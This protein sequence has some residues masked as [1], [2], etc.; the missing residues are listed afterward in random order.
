MK[1]NDC[2]RECGADREKQ[3]GVCGGGALPGIA[4]A[5]LH[6]WEEPCIS[7]VNGSGTV[8]FTG[9]ALRCVFCQNRNIARWQGGKGITVTPERLAD[10]F[11]NLQEQ[12]AHNINLVTPS[13][14]VT[15]IITALNLAKS[16]G[17]R[18]PVVYNTSSYEKVENLR[19]LEGLI[20]IWMPD[21]K[22]F[23]SELSARYSNAPDYFQ[24]ATAA[25]AE[26]VRQAGEPV[27]RYELMITQ[28]DEVKP[29]A[30]TPVTQ[31]D[32]VNHETTTHLEQNNNESAPKT[33]TDSAE[34]Q[35][36]K[37]G[38]LVRHLVLP[39]HTADSKKVL[40]YLYQTYGN[41]IYISIMN[42]YTPFLGEDDSKKYPEL[43]RRVTKR[44]YQRVV[45]YAIELGIENAFIQEGETA[46]ES[47]IP[48]W[49]I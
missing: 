47:F 15:A 18:I 1:C 4:R 38:V 32:K 3:R 27:L 22:Y 36:L 19:R 12:G 2:P 6:F 42:Q 20:D 34:L 37:R 46:E 26:M 45:D 17:L 13:H 23:S 35:L 21:L 33:G 5:A 7:G 8:F 29:V 24:V 9:C 31:S 11:L 41:R 30:A 49:S 14:E 40:E 10:I 16:D 48:E 39:S 25:I 43:T 28:S 44:E